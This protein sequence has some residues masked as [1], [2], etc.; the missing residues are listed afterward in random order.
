[1]ESGL[2]WKN[3]WVARR[4]RPAAEHAAVHATAGR[5]RP[6]APPPAPASLD[7]GSFLLPDDG[8]AIPAEPKGA[9]FGMLKDVLS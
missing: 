2:N 3:P 9:S 8:P 4:R 7:Y 5:H 1:M 6:P